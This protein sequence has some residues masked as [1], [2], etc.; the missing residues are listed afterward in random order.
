MLAKICNL[1][2]DNGGNIIE[3]YHQRMFHDVPVKNAKIDAVIEALSANHIES[4]IQSLRND[5][6]LVSEIREKS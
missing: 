6:F 2:A 1:I 3:I 5:G 4:I